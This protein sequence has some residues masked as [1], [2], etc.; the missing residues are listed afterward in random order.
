M[1]QK[2]RFRPYTC[3]SIQRQQR[4]DFSSF[5]SSLPVLLFTVAHSCHAKKIIWTYYLKILRYSF[6]HGRNEPP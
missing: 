2:H 6:S 3:S 1:K 4:V 5:F